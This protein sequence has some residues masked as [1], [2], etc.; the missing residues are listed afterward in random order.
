MLVTCGLPSTR[1]EKPSSGLD[2]D[3]VSQIEVLLGFGRDY[4]SEVEDGVDVLDERVPIKA[5]IGNIGV[6]LS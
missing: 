3:L 5:W 2:V 6:D 1:F 4:G